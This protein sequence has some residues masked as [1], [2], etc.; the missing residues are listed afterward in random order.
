MVTNVLGSRQGVEYFWNQISGSTCR[1]EVDIRG[2]WSLKN[3]NYRAL[4]SDF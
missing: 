1:I 2:G 3:Y 4:D